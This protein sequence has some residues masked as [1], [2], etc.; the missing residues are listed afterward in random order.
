VRVKTW[1][2]WVGGEFNPEEIDL[3]ETNALPYKLQ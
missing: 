3:E 1:H 2:G